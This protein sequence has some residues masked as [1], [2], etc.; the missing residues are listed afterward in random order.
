MQPYSFKEILWDAPTFVSPHVFY[1]GT[2]LFQ[3]LKMKTLVREE[4][5]QMS[6]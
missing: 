5:S 1:V 6:L 2:I 3:P 4:Q